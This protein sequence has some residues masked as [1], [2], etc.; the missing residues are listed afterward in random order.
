MKRRQEF[1]QSFGGVRLLVARVERLFSRSQQAAFTLS[2]S[3]NSTKGMTCLVLWF[4]YEHRLLI[5]QPVSRTHNSHPA[6]HSNYS[7]PPS[8][9]V[10]VV[11][12]LSLQKF[13]VV[14]APRKYFERIRNSA[15]DEFLSATVMH[16]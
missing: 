10:I 1:D 4:I 13:S 14:N 9:F 15:F 6:K 7:R 3:K 11:L 12:S 2:S 5:I 16:A 8:H